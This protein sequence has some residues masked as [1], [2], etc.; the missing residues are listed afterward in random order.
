MCGRR[1]KCHRN[2][3]KHASILV[4]MKEVAVIDLC[5]P[6]CWS[7][8]GSSLEFPEQSTLLT[9]GQILQLLLEYSTCTK[10]GPLRRF[11]WWLI[12]VIGEVQLI[13]ILLGRHANC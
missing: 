3:T 1:T 13:L 5:G 4:A 8:R 2:G 11:L 12:D 7:I 10:K 6:T 9:A